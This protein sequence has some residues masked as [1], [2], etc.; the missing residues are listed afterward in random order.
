MN[1]EQGELLEL[2]S[3]PAAPASAAIVLAAA[4]WSGPLIAHLVPTA[5]PALLY[6]LAPAGAFALLAMTLI[7]RLS[8]RPAARLDALFAPRDSIYCV[9]DTQGRVVGASEAFSSL[10]GFHSD[11]SANRRLADMVVPEDRASLHSAVLRVLAGEAHVQVETGL[12][13]QRGGIRRIIWERAGTDGSGGMTFLGR[14]VTEER[15]RQAQLRV[16]YAALESAGGGIMLTDRDGVI[17]W[18]N[19]AFTRLVGYRF[20]EVVGRTPRFLRSGLH[21]E[22]D[23]MDIRRTLEAGL[24]WSGELTNRKADGGLVEVE[25]LI[26]PVRTPDGEVTHFV[27]V[28]QDI[29]RRKETEQILRDSEAI[30]RREVELAASV[31]QGLLPR[32]LPRLA[33]YDLAT[34]AVPAR[35]V[36]GDLYD[37]AELPGAGLMLVMADISGKGVPAAMMSSSLRTALRALYEASDGPAGLLQAANR[38]LYDELAGAEM[39]VTCFALL[40]HVPSGRFRYANAGHTSAIIRRRGDGG[41]ERLEA[42]GPPLGIQEVLDVSESEGAL[43]AGDLL[44][45]YSDGLTDAEHESRG[46][47]G[48]DRLEA[49][50]REERIESAEGTV[51]RIVRAAMGHAGAREP[52]DDLTL[53]ALHRSPQGE[54][55]DYPAELRAVDLLTERIEELTANKSAIYS[56]HCRLIAAELLANI[57]RHGYA[58]RAGR[59]HGSFALHGDAAVLEVWERG[60]PFELDR[61]SSDSNESPREGGYGLLILRELCSTLDYVPAG[62]DGNYWRCIYLPKEE[63]E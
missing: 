6:S 15:E 56:Y 53:V 34:R 35:L 57:V 43:N 61:I 40:L 7:L 23:Y 44:V 25:E 54:Y 17:T 27:S 58:S 26:A 59:I 28:M 16:F 21:A 2:E 22:T 45:S 11:E 51:S 39:F 38:I 29:T 18:V 8:H 24:V 47:F 20:H 52:A 37:W 30:L 48:V 46:F 3:G 14:D 50:I 62:F 31:Q 55:F 32:T 60:E 9:L 63:T 13:V 49:H 4:M 12:P 41:L 5:S 33:G 10:T 19:P 36:S 42:G 1:R